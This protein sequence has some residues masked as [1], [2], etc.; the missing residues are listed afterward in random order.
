MVTKTVN[1][2]FYNDII[3]NK[4]TFDTWKMRVKHDIDGSFT[5]LFKVSVNVNTLNHV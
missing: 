5:K 1:I 4:L 2:K 3:P